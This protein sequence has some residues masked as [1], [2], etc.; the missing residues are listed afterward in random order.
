VR[1]WILQSPGD[2][3]LMALGVCVVLGICYGVFLGSRLTAREPPVQFSLRNLMLASV[4]LALWF[5]A[6]GFALP[7]GPS[8]WHDIISAGNMGS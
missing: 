7:G 2:V 8:C 4:W 6:I 3:A 5:V 1:G